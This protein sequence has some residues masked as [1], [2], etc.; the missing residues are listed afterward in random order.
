MLDVRNV[1]S[2]GVKSYLD[3]D[4]RLDEI[5][6]YQGI[7]PVLSDI[8]GGDGSTLIVDD[9]SDEGKTLIDIITLYDIDD[10]RCATLFLKPRTR[11]IPR[12]YGEVVDKWIVFPWEAK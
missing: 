2:V 8:N 11:F 7:K 10:I 9:I 1:Y 12:Y 6:I 4:T 5:D 3:D